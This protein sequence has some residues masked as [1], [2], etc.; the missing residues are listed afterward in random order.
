MRDCSDSKHP[1]HTAMTDRDVNALVKSLKDL[2]FKGEE[3]TRTLQLCHATFGE[4]KQDSYGMIED[5][6]FLIP[7]KPT[8]N[9]VDQLRLARWNSVNAV[10]KKLQFIR[11][12]LVILN[13]LVVFSQQAA[14]RHAVTEQRFVGQKAEEKAMKRGR[15]EQAEEARVKKAKL[16]QPDKPVFNL[17]IESS[18]DQNPFLL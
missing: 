4:L 15:I 12:E 16:Y 7:V 2:S 18:L 1:P 8:H 17:L 5:T 13:R 9:R 10:E 11:K 14:Y 6:E 3:C